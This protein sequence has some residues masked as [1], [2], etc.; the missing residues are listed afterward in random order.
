VAECIV[1]LFATVKSV[2][3]TRKYFSCAAK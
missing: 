1:V 2:F 3:I